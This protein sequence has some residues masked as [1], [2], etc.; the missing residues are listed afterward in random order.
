MS[1]HPTE[2]PQGS[3]EGKNKGS[4]FLGG[5]NNGTQRV[6]LVVGL[7]VLFMLILVFTTQQQRSSNDIALSQLVQEINQGKVSELEVRGGEQIIITYGSTEGGAVAQASS[8]KH[9]NTDI[10]TTLK[11]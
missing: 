3:P 7:V 6:W 9:S 8:Y 11:A 10:F 5:G 1:N 2:D 4:G